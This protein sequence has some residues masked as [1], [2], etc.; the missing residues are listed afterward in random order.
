M[1]FA[2]ETVIW[3]RRI[4]DLELALEQI[5]ACGYEGVEFSQS[6]SDLRIRDEESVRGW[7]TVADIHELLR[8][9][10]KHGLELVSLAGGPLRRAGGVLQRRASALFLHRRVG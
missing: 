3:G 6:V 4:H 9:L 5:K 10:K 1:R 2:F 7:R 8:L